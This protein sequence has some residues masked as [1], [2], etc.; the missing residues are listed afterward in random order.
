ME[1]L[2]I[3]TMRIVFDQAAPDIAIQKHWIAKEFGIVEF[4][5][6]SIFPLVKRE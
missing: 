1:A 3:V 4:C 6:F 5:I 2:K